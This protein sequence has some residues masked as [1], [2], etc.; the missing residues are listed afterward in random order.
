MRLEVMDHGRRSYVFGDTYSLRERL[1][2]IG[3]KW[4]PDRRGW[5]VPISDKSKLEDLVDEVL[6]DRGV[7][8]PPASLSMASDNGPGEDGVVF[9]RA[10]YK[11]R[12]CYVAGWVERGRTRFD[13]FVHPVTT[14]DG[15]KL[16]LYS[17]DGKKKWWAPESSVRI[18]RMYQKPK[19][20]GSIK[21]FVESLKSGELKTCYLCGS[22]NCPGAYGDLCDED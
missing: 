18:E 9:G 16:L 12:P 19:T 4:D 3:A 2:Q 1:R 20:I 8:A 10:V 17:M 22:P 5:Y 13:D 15:T 11:D 7:D 21:R 14:K 6:S